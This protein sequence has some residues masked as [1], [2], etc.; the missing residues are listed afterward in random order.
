MLLLT[1]N[2]KLALEVYAE[3]F[4]SCNPKNTTHSNLLE[5]FKL[6]AGK[7]FTILM[8]VMFLRSLRRKEMSKSY[9]F[10]TY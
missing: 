9:R 1:L 8:Y 3:I 5:V 6:T 4:D 7:F 10:N 2:W